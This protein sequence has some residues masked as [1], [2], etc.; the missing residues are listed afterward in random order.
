LD[1]EWRHGASATLEATDVIASG[2]GAEL[3]VTI[4]GT[5]SMKDYDKDL[6]RSVCCLEQD[7]LL[8]SVCGVGPS[9]APSCTPQL[10]LT[11]VLMMNQAGDAAHLAARFADGELDLVRSD[12]KPID[13]AK[14]RLD[15]DLRGWAGR[16]RIIFP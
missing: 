4:T 6:G 5:D 15:P 10:Q 14:P 11:P 3:V 8:V 9:G 2:T 16:H 1:H 7:F 13:A 12:G